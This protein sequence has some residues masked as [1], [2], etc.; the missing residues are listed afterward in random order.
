MRVNLPNGRK[1]R[2]GDG[3][4]AS[5]RGRVRSPD[6]Q[7]GQF[8]HSR[9]T[10][11]QSAIRVVSLRFT[12]STRPWSVNFRAGIGERLRN[13]SDMKGASSA[14]PRRVAATFSSAIL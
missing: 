10:L 12:A 9:S 11:H 8:F 2:D 14:E 1:V 7:H 5:T 6:M 13:E 3:T 4:I